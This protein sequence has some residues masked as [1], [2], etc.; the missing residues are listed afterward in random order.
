MFFNYKKFIIGLIFSGFFFL[1]IY[2]IS[3]DFSGILESGI[4]GFGSG[5]G[6]YL[7][8]IAIASIREKISYSNVPAPLRGLGINNYNNIEGIIIKKFLNIFL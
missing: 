8:I 2:W 1:S 3:D 5:V 4:Y 7:A 6:W